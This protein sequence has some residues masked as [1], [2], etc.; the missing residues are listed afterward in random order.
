MNFKLTLSLSAALACGSALAGIPPAINTAA[1]KSVIQQANA[2][3]KTAALKP[4]ECNK[5]VDGCG[6]MR[7][8]SMLGARKSDGSEPTE[9]Q[10]AYD[11][12]TKGNPVLSIPAVKKIDN[13]N[14]KIKEIEEEEDARNAPVVKS[15]ANRL[16]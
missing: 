14:K 15:P 1:V 9:K 10:D 11:K 2:S 6:G 13:W 16:P 12:V 4:G 5:L 3:V 7:P 8:P